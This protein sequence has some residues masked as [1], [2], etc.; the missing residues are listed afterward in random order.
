MVLW[1][2]NIDTSCILCQALMETVDHLFFDCPFYEQIWM[3]L[4]RGVM[5][6]RYTSNWSEVVS[7]IMD[8]NQDKLLL[9]TIRYLFQVTVHSI[10]TEMNRRRHR[11]TASP[12]AL[13]AKLIEKTMRNKF[14]IV[15]KKKDMKLEGGLHRYRYVLYIANQE[16]LQLSFFVLLFDSL[17]FRSKLVRSIA[18]ALP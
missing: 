2:A 10:W 18:S 3:S 12:P 8:E 9:F 11:E 5:K 14:S 4:A 7:I 17:R 1:N 16:N 15:Q 13:L 6:D